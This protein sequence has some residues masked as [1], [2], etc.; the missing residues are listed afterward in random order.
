MLE[1]TGPFGA[2]LAALALIA[3]LAVLTWCAS[4]ARSDASLAD[5]M[6]PVF[7]GGAA[8]VY[9][10][11][12]PG[13]GVRA[14]GILV[15]VL[16][17]GL[18]LA[19]YIT[20]RN[21]GHG[22]DR[23]YRQ[24]RARNQPNFGIKSLYL[25]FGLQTA[26]AWI[27]TAP[28]LAGMAGTR[29][30]GLVDAIGL[31]V[32]AFGVAFEAVGDA[33]LASFRADPAHAGRVLDSGLWRYTRHP[34]YFG[35]ACV[36]W[37]LWL[38]ALGAAGGAGAWSAISPLLMTLLLVKVSGVALLEK[39]IAES[40]PAYRDYVSRTRAFLPGPPRRPGPPAR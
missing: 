29:P 5:R 17:W 39:D 11:C 25:V 1:G 37:G 31:A 35:E 19:V 27:V 14:A 38:M 6:W 16:A 13:S 8:L 12:L 34:N 30:L 36:W 9:F 15:L 18:R 22:E 28:I 4:L 40:R 21:W 2:A 33:Q 10:L 24:M 32:A 7:I 20:H 3:V 26:L 23:R